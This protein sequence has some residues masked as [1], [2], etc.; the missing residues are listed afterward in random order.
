M[1][2]P[3]TL[4]P[5]KG[6]GGTAWT[7]KAFCQAFRRRCFIFVTWI[8]RRQAVPAEGEM[9][10]AEPEKWRSIRGALIGAERR[11]WR[12]RVCGRIYLYVDGGWLRS[13]AAMAR[14][15]FDRRWQ[16]PRCLPGKMALPSQLQVRAT[17]A[18]GS[19]AGPEEIKAGQR[20]WI[21][22]RPP[23]VSLRMVSRSLS[24]QTGWMGFLQNKHWIQPVQ[25]GQPNGA[26][27]ND[28]DG[29]WRTGVAAS[30]VS[31]LSV[32]LILDF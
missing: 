25:V 16:L 20:E 9:L 11:K 28:P 23:L 1:A 18:A 3:L 2:R 8:D 17:E 19:E 21:V 12:K 22:D 10:P 27:A 32:I 29:Y 6:T 13:E 4:P 31:A 14:C 5:L 7:A 30:G 24:C 15:A 26:A